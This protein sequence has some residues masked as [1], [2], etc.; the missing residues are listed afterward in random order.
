MQPIPIK[1]R[2][3]KRYVLATSIDDA[4]EDGRQTRF[5][6]RFHSSILEGTTLHSIEL[7]ET[8][9]TYSYNPEHANYLKRGSKPILTSL[10]QGHDEQIWNA[11]WNA[12]CPVPQF[13]EGGGLTLQAFIAS[14]KTVL[15]GVPSVYLDLVPVRTPARRTKEGFGIPGVKSTFDPHLVW[16][17]DHY[18][19]SVQASGRL[20]NIPVCAPPT[21]DDVPVGGGNN[22]LNRKGK[23]HF[24]VGC[25]W[26]AHSFSTR[27]QATISDQST[28]SRLLEFL[29]YHT[30]VAGFDHIYVYDNSL[31]NKTLRHVTELFPRDVVTRI[32]WPHRVCNNN[33]PM[34][35]NPGER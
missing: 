34:H 22:G 26:A 10:E 35:S 32:P 24:L 20:A 31:S 15:H 23:N 6:C 8:L 16:G 11:V 27:G 14:G 7:G 21:V 30:A 28:S 3:S 2:G 12:R 4:D 17:D 25:V 5:I 13:A 9:S 1:R 19:P 33:R 29:T 18:L